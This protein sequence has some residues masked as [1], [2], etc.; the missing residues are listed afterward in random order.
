MTKLVLRNV[1]RDVFSGS[2]GGSQCK[3]YI[4]AFGSAD[5]APNCAMPQ[6]AE[7]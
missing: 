1:N 3:L 5:H 6:R 7:R 2:L 4:R